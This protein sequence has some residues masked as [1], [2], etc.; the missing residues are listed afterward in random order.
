MSD[1]QTAGREPQFSRHYVRPRIHLF[2]DLH[3]VPENIPGAF[4]PGSV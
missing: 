3:R 2:P 1:L 4:L